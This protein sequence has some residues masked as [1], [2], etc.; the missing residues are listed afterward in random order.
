MQKFVEA[1]TILLSLS[2]QS[3]LNRVQHSFLPFVGF[4]GLFRVEKKAVLFLALICRLSLETP[5]TASDEECERCV[6]EHCRAAFRENVF[7]LDPPPILRL[8][9]FAF[10]H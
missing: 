5:N 8:E 9:G 4:P 3:V 6:A 10:L 2:N 7:D 1:R